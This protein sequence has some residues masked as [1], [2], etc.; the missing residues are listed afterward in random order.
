VANVQL[1]P[2]PLVL[3]AWTSANRPRELGLI[4][5]EDHAVTIVTRKR[6]LRVAGVYLRLCGICNRKSEQHC[7]TGSKK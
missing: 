4:G 1:V 5:L 7:C 2:V 3:I 6:D